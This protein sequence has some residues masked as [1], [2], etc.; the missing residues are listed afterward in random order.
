MPEECFAGDGERAK[1]EFFSNV[2][3]QH[4][5]TPMLTPAE[6][7]LLEQERERNTEALRDYA[8]RLMR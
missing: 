6:A 4:P 8:T 5:L 3:P 7:S 1:T 2:S